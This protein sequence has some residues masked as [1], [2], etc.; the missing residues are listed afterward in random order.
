MNWFCDW[1]SCFVNFCGICDYYCNYEW[2]LNTTIFEMILF[3]VNVRVCMERQY[4]FSKNYYRAERESK[5]AHDQGKAITNCAC[6][7]AFFSYFIWCF[8]CSS[9]IWIWIAA[10]FNAIYEKV[11][12]NM[13]Y[14]YS[15]D[16]QC[17]MHLNITSHFYCCF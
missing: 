15:D 13:E 16:G 7:M 4:H 9:F 14:I 17:D 11:W 3:F 5:R 12:A 1:D 10:K 6:Y 8:H 2:P